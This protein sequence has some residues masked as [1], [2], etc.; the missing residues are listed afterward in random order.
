MT[1]RQQD[2]LGGIVAASSQEGAAIAPPPESV[3]AAPVRVGGEVREPRLL[4]SVLPQYPQIA[5]QARAEGDVVIDTQIDAAGNV[6]QMKVVSG[7][8][9]LREAAM[10]ALRHW[11]Y[12]PT[13]LNGQPMPVEMRVVI[14][15]RL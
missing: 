2:G 8:M 6:T 9:L 14:K 7:P 1:G 10:A 11:K 3:P 13:M 5:K 12:E 15:F 4:H